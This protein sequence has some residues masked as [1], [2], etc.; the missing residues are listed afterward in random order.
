[1]F[2]VYT[3][4]DPRDGS[5]FYVGK[6]SKS[7]IAGHEREAAR[8]VYSRKCDRIREIWKARRKPD[9][10]IIEWFEDESA[11][12]NAEAALIAAIGLQNLTNVMPGG[13]VWCPPKPQRRWKEW[14]LVKLA[15]K[16]ARNLRILLT[17][18]RIWLGDH[19]LT[20]DIVGLIRQIRDDTGEAFYREMRAQGLN[21]RP[22]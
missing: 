22:A 15:P 4:V 21:L 3:L 6:G 19:D 10:C 16:I 7:R 5:I 1:M 12:Y 11:A 14:M 2:Y 20:D 8:G 9:R 18:G 13:Q 17:H